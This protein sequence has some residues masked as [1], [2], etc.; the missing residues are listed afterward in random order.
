MKIKERACPLF[1]LFFQNEVVN[2]SKIVNSSK[3][4]TSISNALNHLAVSGS[5]LHE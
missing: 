4:P 1:Y 5:A 3:R 2:I